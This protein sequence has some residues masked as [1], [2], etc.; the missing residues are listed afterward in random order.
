MKIYTNAVAFLIILILGS[1]CNK[2]P[3]GSD[4]D[5][6]QQEEFFIQHSIDQNFAGI[7]CI[8]VIDLDSDGDLD[9]VG[10][11][12][13]T[14]NSQSRGIAWWRNNGGNP[15]SWTRFTVDAGFD[16]VMSV[17]V[18]DLDDDGFSDIIA[19]SWNLHQIAWWKNPGNP[20]SNWTKSIILSDFI[21]AHDAKCGDFNSDGESEVAGV[22][23]GG[24]VAVCFKEGPS[25]SDWGYNI[26]SGTF[27]GGKAIF[28]HDIDN[29][30]D[31][32]LMGIAADANRITW[33][34]NQQG[35]PINWLS[36]PVDHSFSGGSSLD[37]VDMNGDGLTDVIATSW[38]SNTLAYWICQDLANNQ[39]Q[40]TQVSNQLDVAVNTRVCDLDMDGDIDIVA[41][42]KIPGELA[43]YLNDNFSWSKQ[44]LKLGFEGGSALSVIDLDGDGDMDIVSGASALGRLLWWEN[45]AN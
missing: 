41:V 8:K 27:R 4:T 16:H 37:L 1:G 13:V 44:T 6:E 29:D 40:K 10:G 23:S 12:E 20:Q 19:T 33:W 28:I 2:N 7:H 34:E 39:W 38:K 11:S 15:I 24:E 22:S 31:D 30:G 25:S 17:E 35:Q 36:H 21:N 32:D 14:P 26:L 9:V 42:G 45:I 5:T 18:C 43:I 3:N